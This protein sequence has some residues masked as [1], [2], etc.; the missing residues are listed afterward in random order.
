[1][2]L[3]NVAVSIHDCGYLIKNHRQKNDHTRLSAQKG[4]FEPEMAVW[5]NTCKKD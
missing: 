3:L 2:D 1:M 5:G 4:M